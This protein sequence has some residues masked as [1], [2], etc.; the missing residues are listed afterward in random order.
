VQVG[1]GTG[2]I[3]SSG[4]KV[5]ATLAAGDLATDSVTAAAVAA[6]A[7]T[8][9]QAGL[10]TLDGAAVLTQVNSALDTSIAELGVAAPTATPTLRTGLML[11]YMRLRNACTGT[12]TSRTVKNNAGTTICSSTVSDDGTTFNQG[13]LA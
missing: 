12:A 8:K 9:I 10:S 1:T 7:V 11:L 3:N 5:P 6:A 13:K 4:G 2:Q